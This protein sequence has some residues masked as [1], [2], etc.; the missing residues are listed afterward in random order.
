MTSLD[1]RPDDLEL[2]DYVEVLR[3]RRI[4]FAVTAAIVALLV[5]LVQ[6][7]LAP[8]PTYQ[9]TATVLIET[10]ATAVTPG[11]GANDRA[12]ASMETDAV[13]ATSESVAQLAKKQFTTAR[14]PRQL[15]ANVSVSVIPDTQLLRVSYSDATP[16]QARDGANAFAD[17]FLEVRAEQLAKVAKERSALVTEEIEA[18]QKQISALTKRIRDADGGDVEVI[19][20]E[21]TRTTLIQQMAQLENQAVDERTQAVSVGTMF[22][23]AG[24][25]AAIGNPAKRFR[26]VLASSVLA[27]LLIGLIVAFVSDRLDKR[28]ATSVEAARIAA[29]PVLGQLTFSRRR[30]V[31]ELDLEDQSLRRLRSAVTAAIDRLRSR[32]LLITT[33][34]ELRGSTSALRLAASL[35]ESGRRVA[36]VVVGSGRDAIEHF[37]AS[38]DVDDTNIVSGNAS[39]P[40]ARHRATGL[41]IL[42]ASPHRSPDPLL[43]PKALRDALGMLRETYEIVLVDTP[44]ALQAAEVFDCAAVTQGVVLVVRL[45][46]NSKSDLA[47]VSALLQRTGSDVLGLIVEATGRSTS[48]TQS[49]PIVQGVRPQATFARHEAPVTTN[50]RL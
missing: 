18:L 43:S 11:S 35:A 3:R 31:D 46:N 20:L 24:S 15:L 16:E 19:P 45:R 40:V 37:V 1:G 10:P 28:V 27:G 32:S 6:Q 7:L 4:T 25:A 26:V 50:G 13:M 38:A 44:P 41:D 29:A 5:V 17:A 9:S 42:M 2:R 47:G 21:A 36:L 30:S 22:E 33:P 48:V 23:P 8:A 12:R 14:E 34:A 49:E 39:I